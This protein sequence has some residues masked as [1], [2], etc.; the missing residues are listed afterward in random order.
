[1]FTFDS[2]G[3]SQGYL[4]TGSSKISSKEEQRS[5]ALAFLGIDH[6]LQSKVTS[7]LLWHQLQNCLDLS[8]GESGEQ[9]HRCFSSIN[10]HGDH[11]ED[12]KIRA[13]IISSRWVAFL[14]STL[15]LR[16][17]YT[18]AF[19]QQEQHPLASLS[20]QIFKWWSGGL[21]IEPTAE[22]PRK[23]SLSKQAGLTLGQELSLVD[24][25]NWD[26]LKAVINGRFLNSSNA[27]SLKHPTTF[28]KSGVQNLSHMGWGPFRVTSLQ[29]PIV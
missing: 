23:Q 6:T 22:V 4:V 21:W 12:I 20:L 14:P 3:T 5:R 11:W 26:P 24:T 27:L 8:P 28:Q 1:M 19:A 10:V 7:S 16:W 17:T 9:W 29:R 18:S 15:L 25:L 2:L 13:L